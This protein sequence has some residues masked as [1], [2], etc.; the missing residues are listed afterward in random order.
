MT[1]SLSACSHNRLESSVGHTSEA[2]Q[3]TIGSE[4]LPVAALLQCTSAALQPAEQ[5]YHHGLADWLPA[6]ATS[7]AAGCPM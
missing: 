5:P 4:D 3:M 1:I 7:A 6:G 2:R